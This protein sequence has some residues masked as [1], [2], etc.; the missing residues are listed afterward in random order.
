M[1]RN[2]QFLNNLPRVIDSDGNITHGPSDTVIEN[3]KRFISS[4]PT[5]YQRII[6]PEEC[7]TATGH[8]TIVFDWY[9]KKNLVSVEIGRTKIGWF[10]ELPDG[11]NP[12]SEGILL[13][14]EPP[15]EVVNCL[16]VIYNRKD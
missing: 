1:D 9:Y 5:Y 11:S 8:G 13:S 3:S 7:I 12:F 10:T 16:N 6:D 15:K 4:L 14:N 2:H